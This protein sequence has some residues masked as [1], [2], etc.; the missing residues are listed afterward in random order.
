MNKLRMM[1]KDILNDNIENIGTLFP[2]C[3]TEIKEGDNI[4]KAIDFDLLKQELADCVVDGPVERYHLDWP[5]KKESLLAANMPI[6][7]TL[8]PVRKDSI[9]FDQTKNL[10]IEGDNLDALKL[11]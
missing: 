9:N 6:D 4:K 8:R 1:S 3:I 2:N 7:K 5:G 11:L 10:Y